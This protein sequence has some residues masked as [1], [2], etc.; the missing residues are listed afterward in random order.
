MGE[1]TYKLH[2][3]IEEEE[4]VTFLITKEIYDTVKETAA[5][6]LDELETEQGE[7]E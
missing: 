5:R 7:D 1:K 4:D 3:I 6:L 2:C